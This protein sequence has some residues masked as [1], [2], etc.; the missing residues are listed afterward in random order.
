MRDLN[1]YFECQSY[2]KH[3]KNEI[4]KNL[5]PSEK[6]EFDMKI[7]HS[8]V[9]TEHIVKINHEHCLK[10]TGKHDYL[11]TWIEHTINAIYDLK[12]QDKINW[13]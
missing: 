7:R 6:I 4:S 10:L 1:N 13:L 3:L 11:L 9:H 5:L 12:L 8:L 2:C